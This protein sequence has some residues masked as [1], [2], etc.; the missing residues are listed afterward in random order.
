M[1]ILVIYT[2][3]RSESKIRFR[4]DFSICRGREIRLGGE[5]S[6]KSDSAKNTENEFQDL[7]EK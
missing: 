2:M 5:N 7:K 1:N 6:S 4:D 3:E